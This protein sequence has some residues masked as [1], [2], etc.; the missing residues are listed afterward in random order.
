MDVEPEPTPTTHAAYAVAIVLV[1]AL[2]GLERFASGG[3]GRD[4]SNE[5]EDL[6]A[7]DTTGTVV[8]SEP[9]LPV[10]AC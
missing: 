3:E 9:V 5:G 10:V 7:S 6:M 2:A 8:V 1:A 4:H